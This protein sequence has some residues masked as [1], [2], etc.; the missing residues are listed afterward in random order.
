MKRYSSLGTIYS[1]VLLVSVFFLVSISWAQ[2][3]QGMPNCAKYVTADEIGQIFGYPPGT[4]TFIKEDQSLHKC[5]LLWVSPAAQ[6]SQIDH[7][8]HFYVSLP[9][10]EQTIQSVKEICNRMINIGK[11]N[12]LDIGEF[13]CSF[14]WANGP[15]AINFIKN[16]VSVSVAYDDWSDVPKT[17]N[18]FEKEMTDLAKLIADRIE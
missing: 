7:S 10:D 17:D 12:A 9:N 15:P 5:E 2:K 4:K 13:S 18:P 1:C 16:N 11:G 8:G 3:N 6:A 14:C